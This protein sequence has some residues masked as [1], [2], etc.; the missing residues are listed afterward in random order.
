M[1]RRS[2]NFWQI[3][4]PG[5]LYAASA[6]GLS[7]LVQA[8]RAGADYGLGLMLL[9]ILACV[10][11]YPALRFGSQYA[12]ATGKTLISSYKHEGWWAYGIFALA[13]LLAMVFI[14]AAISLFTLGLVKAAFGFEINDV[15]GVFLL[16]TFVAAMLL[17]GKYHLLERFNKYIF[18]LLTGLIIAATLLVIPHVNWSISAFAVPSIDSGLMMYLV[19]LVGFMPTPTDASVLQ[20]LWTCAKAGSEGVMPSSE[21]SRLDYNTGY[22]VSVVLAL[23]F[24]ILGTGLMHDTGVEMATSNGGFAAQLIQLFTATIG[25]WSFPF[26][27]TAA[28]FVMMTT[29]FTVVDGMTRIVAGIIEESR[30]APSKEAGRQKLYNIAII[31]L[32]LAAVVVIATMM[33]S[34][35]AFIDMTSVLVFAVSPILAFLNHRAITSDRVPVELQPNALLRNWSLISA[36][37]LSVV[38]VVYFYIRLT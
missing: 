21:E 29:L 12:V 1:K 38:T 5:V 18:S 15:L 3:L 10:I 16:L 24:L 20:S 4:G 26:I 28:I 31:P 33:K 30:A 37:I 23:C 6:V 17:T 13:E 25:G 7:H 8:T 32:C 14:I 27:S 19:A 11:K 22:T 2:K 36:I 35:A 34:F 9:L